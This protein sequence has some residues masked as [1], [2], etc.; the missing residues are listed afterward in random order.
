MSFRRSI[1]LIFLLF[2]FLC[3]PAT[4]HAGRLVPGA[5]HGATGCG[6]SFCGIQDDRA[7]GSAMTGGDCAVRSAGFGTA[8][9]QRSCGGSA[10]AVERG[11]GSKSHPDYG[12]EP[13]LSSGTERGKGNSYPSLTAQGRADF[14]PVCWMWARRPFAAPPLSRERGAE[15]E[16][17]KGA[18][19][20]P[21]TAYCLPF[22]LL[23]PCSLRPAPSSHREFKLKVKGLL[24]VRS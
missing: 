19:R 9:G 7:S 8:A 22:S 16:E 20:S 3:F 24:V 4:A 13:V 6:Q 18:L 11:C 15:G 14:S 1:C 23:A 12:V 5:K 17:P 2:C 10:R 21:L